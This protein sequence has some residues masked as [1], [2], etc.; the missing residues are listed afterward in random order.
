MK[1][2][3]GN[4]LIIGPSPPPYFGVSL[5]TQIT[6]EGFRDRGKRIL[7]L[8]TSD[9]RDVMNIGKFD[10]INVY[11]AFLHI[12]KLLEVLRKSK[13]DLVYLPLSQGIWG[14]LRDAGFIFVSKLFKRRIVI[15]LRGGRF[16][17]FYVES[18]VILRLLI[19][20]TLKFVRSGIVQGEC[21]I[22]HL[23]PFLPP[24]RIEVLPNG[25]D[26]SPFERHIASKKITKNEGTLTI[27]F[28]SNLH[29]TK[30]F[31]DLLLAA[32]LILKRHKYVKFKFA[33][34]WKSE[35]WKRQAYGLVD[36]LKLQNDI[37]FLGPVLGEQKYKILAD[38]DIFVFP[39]FYPVEGH[40][41]VILEAMASG[42]P[43]ITTDQ[44][45][46]KETVLDGETG[47]IINKQNPDEIAD[48]V[49]ILIERPELRYKMGNN[50]RERLKRLYTKEIF[51]D[52]LFAI[53]SLAVTGE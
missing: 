10:V 28:L 17:T 50:A 31:M 48:K 51:L 35:I 24:E 29:K 9:K 14:F 5:A 44:G 27:L 18:N 46:I 2:L 23:E 53:L 32:P 52:R 43:I 13:V 1:K 42:L 16:K 12:F 4:I 3:K 41:W 39:T 21:L 30:G 22:D 47:F 8:D 19:K 45:C 15:H 7:H 6:V 37:E 26:P 11:L 36:K 34:E 33:G 40:P 25:L 38:S 20:I 49:N